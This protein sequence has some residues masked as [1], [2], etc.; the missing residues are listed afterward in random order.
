MFIEDVCISL[1]VLKV[2]EVVTF[3]QQKK[4]ENKWEKWLSQNEPG[5]VSSWI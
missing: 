1:S 5:L 4:E 2:G 3:K